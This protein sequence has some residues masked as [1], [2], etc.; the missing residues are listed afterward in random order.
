MINHVMI[1]ALSTFT[2]VLTPLGAGVTA[3]HQNYHLVSSDPV[4]CPK[5][6]KPLA[7]KIELRGE[8]DVQLE[9]SGHTCGLKPAEKSVNF[10]ITLPAHLL[11]P[12]FLQ[13]LPDHASFVVSGVGGS[14]FDAGT[15][16]TGPATSGAQVKITRGAP[17][18]SHS[19]LLIEWLP[20]HDGHVLHPPMMVWIGRSHLNR[21]FP[22]EKIQFAELTSKS[23]GENGTF[24]F[25]ESVAAAKP[26][27]LNR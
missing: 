6:A 19:P 2:S 5:T 10:S 24:T 11:D 14:D 4:S 17:S 18:G 23:K 15:D 3:D 25:S 1:G 13:H 22:W 27:G 12:D 9:V 7:L 16:G 8:Q 20:D 26:N 21:D